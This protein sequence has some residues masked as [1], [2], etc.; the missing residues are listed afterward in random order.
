MNNNCRTQTACKDRNATVHDNNLE[1]HESNRSN[2]DTEQ[3]MD[4]HF[5]PSLFLGNLLSEQS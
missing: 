3:I 4:L 2:Q 5:L 1:P